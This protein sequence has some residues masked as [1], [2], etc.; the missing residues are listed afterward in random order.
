MPPP[1]PPPPPVYMSNAKTDSKHEANRLNHLTMGKSNV[2]SYDLRIV[3]ALPETASWNAVLTVLDELGVGDAV[4]LSVKSA[5]F[6][7]DLE[8]FQSYEYPDLELA[9]KKGNSDGI[10]GMR[11]ILSRCFDV[12]L[13]SLSR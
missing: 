1:P 8:S 6:R 11:A 3:D 12:P 5:Y 9:F 2:F 4:V 7:C 13:G 10:N